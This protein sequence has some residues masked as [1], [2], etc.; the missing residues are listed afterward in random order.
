M[1]LEVLLHLYD[2]VG[3]GTLRLV[4]AELIVLEYLQTGLSLCLR[5]L[6]VGQSGVGGDDVAGGRHVGVLCVVGPV[7]AHHGGVAL[8][9]QPHL[10]LTLAALVQGRALL[11]EAGV[12]G[13]ESLYKVVYLLCRVVVVSVAQIAQPAVE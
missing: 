4:G 3:L 9:L 10:V 6:A 13:G 2:L 11:N 12:V 1:G 7:Q 5:W 8:C